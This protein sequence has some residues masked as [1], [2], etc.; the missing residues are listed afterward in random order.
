MQGAGK[1]W[2]AKGPPAQRTAPQV[3]NAGGRL[4][5]ATFSPC[6]FS[7]SHTLEGPHGARFVDSEFR[8]EPSDGSR[9]SAESLLRR[10][11]AAGE[12]ALVWGIGVGG[13]S[14]PG[15][16]SLHATSRHWARGAGGAVLE[17]RPEPRGWGEEGVAGGCRGRGPSRQAQESRLLAFSRAVGGARW[18]SPRE[19]TPL[20]RVLPVQA[21]PTSPHSGPRP[22]PLVLEQTAQGVILCRCPSQD[23]GPVQ[24]ASEPWHRPALG[25]PSRSVPLPAG[26]LLSPCTAG[27]CEP[28]SC[29]PRDHET[30]ATDG[31]GPGGLYF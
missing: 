10:E 16:P 25:K 4:H 21:K 28:G 23:T 8:G 7:L 15:T 5:P 27:A 13:G 18:R 11:G 26:A 29:V 31:G 1:R 17:T 22:S 12:R 6:S 3:R 20:W 14:C 19:P 24:G 9:V 30:Q 2:G